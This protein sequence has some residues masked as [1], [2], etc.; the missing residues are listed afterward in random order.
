M[1]ELRNVSKSYYLGGATK[2]VARNI[3]FVFPTGT[4]IA[5]LGRN[6]SGKSSML[7]MIAGTIEADSG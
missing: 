6:G 3:S 2:T 4:S 7:S 1:I 5:L